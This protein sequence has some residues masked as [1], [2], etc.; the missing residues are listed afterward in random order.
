MG[1]V[2]RL[3]QQPRFNESGNG[4]T[5]ESRPVSGGEAILR[6]SGERQ[7][8]ETSLFGREDRNGFAPVPAGKLAKVEE[9][10]DGKPGAE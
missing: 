4:P 3:R 9:R 2:P 6:P 8:G 10:E 7:G 1:A 5:D